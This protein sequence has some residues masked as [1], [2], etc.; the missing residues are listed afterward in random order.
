MK[1]CFFILCLICAAIP[2]VA[3]HVAGGELFYEYLGP[4][5]AGY[6]KYK[7][8]LRLFRDCSSN[9]P[10]LESEGVQVGIYSN[11]NFKRISGVNLPITGPV[12]TI[13]LNTSVFPCLVGN[14]SVCY[15]IAIYTN[16]VS[17]PDNESGYTLSRVGCCRIDYISNLSDK[18]NVG[19][20]YVTYIPGTAVLGTGHNSSPQFNLRDTA[21]VCANKIFH[22][23]FGATDP[24]HDSLTYSFCDSYTALGVVPNS[25]PPDALL[26]TPLPYASPYTGDSPLGDAV[27]INRATGII[28][29]IAPPE[30]QYVV[31]VCID[32][33]R[34]GQVISHHRKDFILKVQ[35]CDFI[36][37]V[38]PDK[39]IQC[40]DSVVHFENQSTSSSIQSY[41]WSFGDKV[42]GTSTF[43][44]IDYR[45]ADTGKYLATLMV[46]GPR[47]CVGYDTTEVYVYPGFN[48]AFTVTGNCA[49]IPYQFTDQTYTKYGFVNSWRWDF[50]D[51]TTRADTSGLQNP[52]YRYPSPATNKVKLVVSSSKGCIDSLVKNVVVNGRP[53]LQLPFRDTLICN[54]DTLAIPVGNNGSFSW[55]PNRDILFPNSAN[56]LVFPKDTTK[57]IVTVNEN[58][59][60]NTDTVTVNVLPFITVKLGND[61]LICQTDQIELHPVSQAVQYKWT[62]STGEI[63]R[64]IKFPTVRP[65]V[66]TKYYVTASLG[67]C[68]DRDS[69]EIKVLPYPV[70]SIRPDTVICFGQRIT[71]NSTIVASSFSW[72]PVSSLLNP[73]S[74]SPIAGPSKTTRYYLRAKDTLGCP[75]NV[76]DSITV[77]VAPPV[78]A[79]AG[80]DT[81]A[82]PNQPLQLLAGTGFRYIWSPEFGL[83]NP[84]VYNPVATLPTGIDSIRYVVRVYDEFG[85]YADDD[86]L[87][88]V[89]KSLPDIIVPS[90][91]TPNGD[92]LNDLLRPITPGISTI[93]YFRVYN[94]WGQ[95]LFSTN[96]TGQGWDGSYHG[97]K[98]P[99]GTYV[100]EAAGVDYLGNHLLRKGTA[101]LIR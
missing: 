39:T 22:L 16:I 60:V 63:V 46:T 86:I 80:K 30:G 9:G 93:T 96:T 14:V 29:G 42:S 28:S 59:C 99:P 58:G 83:S 89:F 38:L 92:G 7:I 84:S 82:L 98:Q 77:T 34:N 81:I 3:K 20:N 56:P 33:W 8:T 90:A 49:L 13:S 68:Q 21:L 36:E 17:L 66:N 40:K 100:Y 85:C 72:S 73:N 1:K 94:R 79:N 11:D 52:L 15:Q 31:N 76:I 25:P 53:P 12:T 101:V 37:A 57:Y 95:M 24:D 44:S 67:K 64:S 48:P 10:F 69:I 62:A 32:E 45:Y 26:T 54:I 47:G 51:S 27:T 97:I 41:L 70:A 75:K 19:S 55:T 43:P 61:S 65:L 88:K 2:A 50:G 91:F 74:T 5:G 87:I 78:I 4:A 23:D 18:T 6:S 71:L 35:N